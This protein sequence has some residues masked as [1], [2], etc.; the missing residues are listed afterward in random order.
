MIRN[1]QTKSVTL[2]IPVVLLDEIDEYAKSQLLSRSSVIN[3]A[4]QSYLKSQ[5]LVD[6]ML[7]TNFNELIK[8]QTVMAEY[9]KI[10]DT[11]GNSE[12]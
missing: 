6:K 3:L 11:D 7:E 4:L 12:V 10:G 2:R 5:K 1:T 8:Q 9:Q